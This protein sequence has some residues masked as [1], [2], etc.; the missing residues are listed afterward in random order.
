MG[1]V[2]RKVVFSG[3]LCRSDSYHSVLRYR[4]TATLITLILATGPNSP[5]KILN[6]LVKSFTNFSP[7][8]GEKW[9]AAEPD[10]SNI[11]IEEWNFD[12]MGEW[13]VLYDSNW[14]ELLK[15]TTERR[16]IDVLCDI[17]YGQMVY[18]SY[19]LKP[20]VLEDDIKS[21]IEFGFARTRSGE[22]VIDE[23]L[24]VMAAWN[25]LDVRGH[26]S[27]LAS[28]QREVGKH[29]PRKNAFEA[30]IAFYLRHVFEHTQRLNEVFSFRSDFA[31]RMDL[32]L[33]WQTEGFEL[34]TVSAG[35]PGG[36]GEQK[37]S[38]VTPSSGPSSNVG[39]LAETN[40]DVLNWISENKECYAFCFPTESAG[41]DILFYVRS[42]ATG[43]LL[44]VAVQAKNYK[45]VKKQALVQ[46]VGSV[47]PPFWKKSKGEKVRVTSL[48][49]TSSS[50]FKTG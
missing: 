35:I 41:P 20:W 30:Y 37:I 24:V 45:D 18:G 40:D 44:L 42:K 31:R 33:S 49:S 47:T 32:D 8:D 48:C 4:S 12:R 5:H 46:G 11:D 13:T 15:N 14:L 22:H 19:A 17:L 50:D 43:R 3:I 21:F 9:C 25:W 26:F 36:T 28:L 2:P 1:M 23:P 16:Q 34:V 7:T 10:V 27:L 29:A 38:V 6:K 39:F